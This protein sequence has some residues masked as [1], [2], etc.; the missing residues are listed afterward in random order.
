M[1]RFL[2]FLDRIGFPFFH[3]WVYVL[4]ATAT[5]SI[6][7][8]DLILTERMAKFVQRIYGSD[9]VK[10]LIEWQNLIK[11]NMNKI[12]KEKLTAV[13]DFFNHIPNVSDMDNWGKKDYWATPLELLARNGGDCEDFAIAKYFTLRKLNV[14]DK[15]LCLTYVRAYSGRKRLVIIPHLVLTYYPRPDGDP[16]VLDN[17][18]PDILPASQR[19]D[20]MPTY[21]FNGDG[22]WNSKERNR[23]KRIGSSKNIYPWQDLLTR[24]QEEGY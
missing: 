11:S 23:G 22:L 5:T 19:R 18:L 7:T 12:E 15:R 10:R 8:D 24:I 14:A 3:F 2:V 4:L 21:S 20:L 1:N 16:F 17:L 13:N 6:A 9:A